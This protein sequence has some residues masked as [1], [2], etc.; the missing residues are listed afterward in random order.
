MSRKAGMQELITLN[1][2]LTSRLAFCT[3]LA[4]WLPKLLSSIVPKTPRSLHAVKTERAK[5]SQI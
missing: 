5:L 4:T 1:E 3:V 2:V